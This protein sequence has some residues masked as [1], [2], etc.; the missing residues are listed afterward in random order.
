[1]ENSSVIEMLK[2]SYEEAKNFYFTLATENR[3]RYLEKLKTVMWIEIAI[4]SSIGFLINHFGINFFL[5]LTVF[6]LFVNLFFLVREFLKPISVNVPDL[7]KGIDW[8]Y[9]LANGDRAIEQFFIAKIE[10]FSKRIESEH[11]RVKE[12]ERM[13]RIYT[14][15]VGVQF[16]LIAITIFKG[17]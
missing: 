14:A 17:G 9:E 15:I 1:M 5:L 13:Y 2:V 6:L 10:S 4:L 12:S 3:K 11:R 8:I 7:E 16:V